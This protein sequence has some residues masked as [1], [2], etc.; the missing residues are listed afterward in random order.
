MARRCG[1]VEA[2]DGDGAERRAVVGDRDLVAGEQRL[3]GGAVERGAREPVLDGAGADGVAV[4]R[5]ASNSVV[6]LSGSAKSRSGSPAWST[7]RTTPSCSRA[8]TRALSYSHRVGDLGRRPGPRRRRSPL[9]DRAAVAPRRRPGARARPRCRRTA[10]ARC[11][12]PRSTRAGR[13]EREPCDLGAGDVVGDQVAVLTRN[14]VRPSVLTTSGS[15]TPASCTL[16][17][18]SPLVARTGGGARPAIARTHGVAARPS[19]PRTS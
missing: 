19:S 6:W 18:V 14:S 15:S 5:V 16:V 12:P 13:A 1:S 10:G 2:D 11:C 8:V 9:G 7:S 17:P 4:P 3:L